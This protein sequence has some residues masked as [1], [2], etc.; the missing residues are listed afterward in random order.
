MI[1]NDIR[2]GSKFF[3][4]ITSATSTQVE[5]V[6]DTKVG[7]KRYRVRRCDTGAILRKLRGPGELHV[8]PG[9]WHRF[10]KAAPV[11]IPAAA[12]K[13]RAV[14]TMSKPSQDELLNRLA[15][16]APDTRKFLVELIAAIVPA[17]VQ[18]AAAK[19]THQ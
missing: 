14:R 9:P 17:S 12:P 1:P 10:T 6:E 15:T 3:T 7:T 13:P 5:V 16:L 4:R 11:V 8:A 18:E 19:E 2:I